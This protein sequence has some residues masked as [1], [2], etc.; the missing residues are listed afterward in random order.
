MTSTTICAGSLWRRAP[1]APATA[2]ESS[3]AAIGARFPPPA[4]GLLVVIGVV[5]V[6]TLRLVE[7]RNEAVASADRA[8]RIQDFMSSLFEGGDPSAG[9]SESLRVVT[10]LD[11]GEQEARALAEEP[12][13]QAD[14]YQTLGG[15]HHALGN[16]EKADSLMSSSLAQRRALPGNNQRDIARSLMTLGVLRADQSDYDDAKLLVREALDASERAEPRDAETVAQATTALGYILV[17]N[18]EYD[19]AIRVLAEAVQLHEA[20]GAS[21]G[22]VAEAA[23]LL[24]NAHFYSGHYALSDSLNREILDTDRTAYGERHPHV[25]SDLINLGAVQ[26]EWGH[27]AEAEQFYRQALVIFQSWYGKEHYETA[28][29]MTMIGRALIPQGKLAEASTLLRDALVIRERVYGP[30]HPSVASTLSELGKVAQQEGRLDEAE[31]YFRRM[32]G[33]YKAAYDDKHYLIGVALSNLGSVVQERGD[34][35]GAERL[36]REVIRRYEETLSPEHLYMGITRIKLGRALLRQRRYAEA[37]KET[38]AGYEILIA[39]TDPSV[40]WVKSARNDLVEEYVALN[41]PED[42]ARFRA[43]LADTTDKE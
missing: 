38:R 9:P 40:T 34:V 36:F 25:A 11:R 29:T 7:A 31:A 2:S 17:S 21:P 22:E 14:L 35:E 1:T 26:S 30:D 42:A 41:R 33:I 27:Y 37:E 3:C 19:E 43:E 4:L 16:F 23:T 39:Q 8:Q 6:Y 20:A 32:A 24:A 12:A 5:V 13:V 28:S 18:G 15:I 10:L